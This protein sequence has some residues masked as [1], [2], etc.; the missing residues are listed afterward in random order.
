MYIN[1]NYIAA[2]PGK[3]LKRKN[4]DEIF[5]ED[6]YLGYSYYI[7]GVKLAEPHRD[8]PEDFEEITDVTTL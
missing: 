1:G 2:D 4:S 3:I 6:F 7:D 8:V 5:G